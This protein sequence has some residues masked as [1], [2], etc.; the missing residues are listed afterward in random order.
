MSPFRA[1][2]GYQPPLFNFQEDEVAVP[3]VRRSLRPSWRVWVQVHST[4]TRSSLQS[5]KQ[6]NHHRLLV[7]LVQSDKSN[8][9]GRDNDGISMFLLRIRRPGLGA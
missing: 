2:L 7:S 6:A 5:Q 9:E 3:S 8:Q 4:L 1:S